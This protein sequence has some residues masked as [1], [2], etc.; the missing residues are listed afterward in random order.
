MP[1]VSKRQ[2]K[3]MGAV[4]GGAIE[5]PG[6]SPEKAKEFVRGVKLKSLPKKKS[7][8]KVK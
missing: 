8:K 3:F 5:R 6:L 7:K 4:A 1:A 2:A